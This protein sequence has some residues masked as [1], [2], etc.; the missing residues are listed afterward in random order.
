MFAGRRGL[1]EAI[2]READD[3]SHQKVLMLT[4]TV[5]MIV[6]TICIQVFRRQRMGLVA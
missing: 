1:R 2:D 6:S 3:V 5:A 4:V